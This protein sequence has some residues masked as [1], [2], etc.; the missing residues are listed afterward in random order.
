MDNTQLHRDIGRLESQV[1]S[2][3]GDVAI[4]RDKIDKMHDII[5]SA[6]GGW[7]AI[8]ISASAGA[9]VSALLLNVKRIFGS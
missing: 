4:M 1:R 5:T 3:E 7:R 6:G 8:I 2:L 9:T